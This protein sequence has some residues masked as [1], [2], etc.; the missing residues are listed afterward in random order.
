MTEQVAVPRT[1]GLSVQVE[2]L[3]VPEDAGASEKVTVPVGVTR[4]PGLVSVTVAVQVLGTLTGTEAGE[5]DIEVEVARFV[6]VTVTV[7]E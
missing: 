2:K 6:T 3:K 1:P 4:V 7:V 5:H